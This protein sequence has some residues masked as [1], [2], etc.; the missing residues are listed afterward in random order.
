MLNISKISKMLLISGLVLAFSCVTFDANLAYAAEDPCLAAKKSVDKLQKDLEKKLK[1]AQDKTKDAQK[2]MD[3][4]KKDCDVDLEYCSAY[5][6]ALATYNASKKAENDVKVAND[7]EIKKAQEEASKSCDAK[8]TAEG[9]GTAGEKSKSD[10]RKA[11]KAQE[12]IDKA[13][14]KAGA[15]QGKADAA[16]GKADEANKKLA[17]EK[18]RVGN[19]KNVVDGKKSEMEA[20]CASDPNSSACKA[21]QTSYSN[22][23]KKLEELAANEEDAVKAAQKEAD[24]ANKE[25]DRAD[26]KADKADKKADK[27]DAKADKAQEKDEKRAQKA[28]DNAQKDIDKFCALGQITYNEEKCKKA[29]DDLATAEA[30][31]TYQE[32]TKGEREKAAQAEEAKKAKAEEDKKAKE[33]EVNEIK[34]DITKA[35]GNYVSDADLISMQGDLASANSALTAAE[36]KKAELEEAQ[37]L[38]CAKPKSKACAKA[39]EELEAAKAELAT[40]KN[41]Q[42]KA[43]GEY[44]QAKAKNAAAKEAIQSQCGTPEQKESRECI[45]SMQSIREQELSDAKKGLEDAKASIPGYEKKLQAAENAYNDALSRQAIACS[46]GQEDSEACL[47]AKAELADA[48]AAKEKAAADLELAKGNVEALEV[49]VETAQANYDEAQNAADD[50][51]AKDAQA[52]ADA[53]AARLAEEKRKRQEEADRICAEYG[54]DSGECLLARERVEDPDTKKTI[55]FGVTEHVVESGFNY[56][57]TA[58]GD[59]FEMV[60][61]RA[62][63][64]LIG[65]KPIVYIFAGFGLIAFAWGAIFNKISWK[66]FA[67]IAIGLFLVA[68]VGR[69]IEYFVTN[70]EDGNYYIGQWQSNAPAKDASNE[71]SAA[72]Q[73]SYYVYGAIL[74]DP[75]INEPAP[76]PVAPEQTTGEDGDGDGSAQDEMKKRG[77]CQGDGSLFS[78]IKNCIGDVVG[79]IRKA[80]NVVNTA[81][82]TVNHVKNRVEDIKTAANNIGRAFEGMKDGS[83]TDVMMGMGVVLGNVE[84]IG[85]SVTSAGGAI[86]QGAT[87]V[88][89]NVTTMGDA[90]EKQSGS[91]IRN[92]QDGFQALASAGGTIE[93]EARK[94]KEKEALEQ[95]RRDETKRQIQGT[96][97]GI[98]EKADKKAAETAAAA[99]PAAAAAAAPAAAPAPAAALEATKAKVAAAAAAK[100]PAAAPANPVAA[101][102]AVK[103][104]VAAAPAAKAPAAIESV[105]AKAAPIASSKMATMPKLER[106][107]LGVGMR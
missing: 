84:D 76:V 43:Q 47:A 42:E 85:S 73:D 103:A 34:G 48:K 79:T 81:V 45:G 105:K 98:K 26:K 8:T 97:D 44:D 83:F 21:A 90:N 13:K 25:A 38:A 1:D 99:A 75:V 96:I 6:S 86:S 29:K 63:M 60:T 93:G 2:A 70:S 91:T 68:N 19:Q 33:Q 9:A 35:A 80:A 78:G 51:A 52:A 62:A 3:K 36:G 20:A 61:R 16:Q 53:E 40:A 27:A 10:Q 64:I 22:E 57:S 23:I 65:I 88:F 106:K 55:G 67:N 54:E 89:D 71:L 74:V 92:L 11:D 87:S 69:L 17:E 18:A 72:F 14:D 58:D 32:M 15:A 28:V 30:D 37:K 5:Q 56:T 77:Y 82:A 7:A 49:A 66:H 59:V 50:L 24:K 39:N 31:S 95:R 4:A 107:K 101:I 104:K 94:K 102:E 46:A 12:N 100:A 41:N